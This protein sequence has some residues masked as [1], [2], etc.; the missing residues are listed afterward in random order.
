M[1]RIETNPASVL[2]EKGD[3]EFSVYFEGR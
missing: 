3:R 2:E 1:F